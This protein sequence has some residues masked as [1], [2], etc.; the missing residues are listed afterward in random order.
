MSAQTSP[1][2]N[3]RTMSLSGAEFAASIAKL[4]AH[5][6]SAGGFP[7]FDLEEG[8]VEIRFEPATSRTLGGLLSLP[9]AVVT[10]VFEGAS[11]KAQADFIRRFD[12][13]FQRGGG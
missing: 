13:A 8:A 12:I 2:A 7:V 10:L 5:R 6:T 1:F 3:R 4:G 9:Q 11:S